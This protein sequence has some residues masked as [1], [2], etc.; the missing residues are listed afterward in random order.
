MMK[1]IYI[2][3]IIIIVPFMTA[4]TT[5]IN[6][7]IDL[8]SIQH[9][10][11]FSLDG[12]TVLVQPGTYVENINFNGHN[13]TLG[14]LFLTTGDTSYI[15]TTIIDGD[16]SGSVIIFQNGEDSTAIVTGFTIQN[17]HA[18]SGGGVLCYISSSPTIENNI[19]KNNHVGDSGGG[20]S[21]ANNTIVRNNVIFGNSAWL[22]AGIKCNSG[23]PLIINN[24]ITGNLYGGG[25]CGEGP[26]YPIIIN[27]ILWGNEGGE[28]VRYACPEIEATF[29]DIQ[30][31]WPGD[32]NI[33]IDP[34]FR[35]PQNNNFHLMS[36]DCGDSEDSPCI[37]AGNPNLA[38][39]VLDCSW[40]LGDIRSDMGA[41]GG[42]DSTSSGVRIINVPDDYPL[43]QDAIFASNDLD[44]ILVQPG[45]YTENINF[46]G[47]NVVLGS[48]F[49]TMGDTSYINT[50]YINAGFSG[51]A[52]TLENNEDSNTVICGFTILNGSADYGGGINCYQSDPIIRNNI[53]LGNSANYNGGGI[54]CD[55]SDPVISNNK[56]I[57]NGAQNNGGGIY[58]YSGLTEIVEN[59]FSGNYAINNGGGIFCDYSNPVIEKNTFYQNSADIGGAIT[60]S[61]SNPTINGNYIRDNSSANY[62]GGI[63]FDESNPTFS[64]NILN[65]NSTVNNGGGIFCFASSPTI[66]NNVIFDNYAGIR[67]GGFYCVGYNPIITNTIF[68]ANTAGTGND[69][70]IYS[71]IP[72]FSYCDIQDSILLGTGNISVDPLFKY[73]A[74]GNFHLMDSFCGDSLDSPCIDSGDPDIFDYL[75]DCEWGLGT[76]RSDMGAFGG[77]SLII[78]TGIE[79]LE[80]SLPRKPFIIQNYPN[81]FN[82]QTTFKY[83]LPNASEIMI[84]VYDLLGRK[85]I[86]LVEE[87]K[88]AGNHQVSWVAS[89]VPSGVYFYKIHTENFTG[90]KKMLLLK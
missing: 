5:I 52:I 26:T 8:P 42:G 84:E 39:K 78:I 27:N 76:D 15:F 85:I 77:D 63:Y 33:D 34:L 12:D 75:L 89:N 29:C 50:T 22:G 23:F 18:N 10:I 69:I 83:T 48:L 90:T 74:N 79:D 59:A 60:C 16:S 13:C 30:G 82:A 46:Y 31:G 35:D 37:D 86:T 51:S 1:T 32:G 64:N 67:G 6:I 57:G 4:S 36:I 70:F 2:M 88:Q 43:I 17:G 87:Y 9:G 41:Y 80:P 73:S 3:L 44:T 53:I 49:I 14:S 58:C 66:I 24:T 11:N 38:D 65:L 25:I 81:P 56:F 47:H 19:I 7:P 40:G 54:F 62:G 72:E 55:Q 68:W 20:I 71:G 45:A 28:I 21:C 61:F